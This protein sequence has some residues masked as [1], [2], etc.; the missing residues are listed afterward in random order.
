[1]RCARSGQFGVGTPE[2][3]RKRASVEWSGRG[4]SNPHGQLGRLRSDARSCVSTPWCTARAM[5]GLPPLGARIAPSAADSRIGRQAGWPR[6]SRGGTAA[7][8]RII[9]LELEELSVDGCILLAHLDAAH[10]ASNGDRP[11]VIQ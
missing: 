1:V 8:D 6:R 3:V 7:D 9:G 5:S 11:G 4:G 10:S 2:T